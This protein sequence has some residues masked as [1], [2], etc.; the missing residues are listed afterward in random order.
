LQDLQRGLKDSAQSPAQQLLMKR[1]NTGAIQAL[2]K[3][4]G[5]S[6][7]A[8]PCATLYKQQASIKQRQLPHAL[9]K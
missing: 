5:I 8:A 4:R 7:A 1:S 3:V 6:I 9:E 2:L